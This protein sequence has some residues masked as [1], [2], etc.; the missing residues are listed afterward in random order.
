MTEYSKRR[1]PLGWSIWQ[2]DR[3]IALI[4]ENLDNPEGVAEGVVRVLN[5]QSKYILPTTKNYGGGYVRILTKKEK[6]IQEDIKNHKG[7]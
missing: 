2:G 4:N 5:E 7:L 3:L 1:I 6:K